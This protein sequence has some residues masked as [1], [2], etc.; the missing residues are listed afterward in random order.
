[1]G[2]KAVLTGLILATVGEAQQMG[3]YPSFE[4]ASIRLNN[5]RCGSANLSTD[6]LIRILSCLGFNVRVSVV[7]SAA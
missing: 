4:V 7:K 3:S 5:G 2:Y 6:L 1:M